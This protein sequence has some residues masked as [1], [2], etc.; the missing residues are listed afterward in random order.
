MTPALIAVAIIARAPQVKAIAEISRLRAS[1][2]EKAQDR[3]R[4]RAS[5]GYRSCLEELNG[6]NSRAE[7]QNVREERLACPRQRFAGAAFRLV[8]TASMNRSVVH[9][10]EF[11]PNCV[12]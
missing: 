2:E 1:Q 5:F 8:Y 6:E 10:P 7:V 3:P 11:A 9:G 12:S 4:I